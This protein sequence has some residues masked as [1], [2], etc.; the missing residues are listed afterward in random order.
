MSITYVT[1]S[2]IEC[3]LKLACDKLLSK[4]VLILSLAVSILDSKE[5]DSLRLKGNLFTAV[6]W[7]FVRRCFKTVSDSPLEVIHLAVV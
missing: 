5:A 1:R 3:R 6:S 7:L 4:S 2:L